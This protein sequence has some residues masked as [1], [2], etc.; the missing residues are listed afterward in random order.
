MIGVTFTII[1]VFGI[2][3]IFVKRSI[4]KQKNKKSKRQEDNSDS[5]DGD[6]FELWSIRRNEMLKQANPEIR[7][8]TRKIETVCDE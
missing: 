4:S 2:A 5:D 1:I 6:N 8:V 7:L 3:F